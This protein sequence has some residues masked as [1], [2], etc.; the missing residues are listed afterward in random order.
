M[1]KCVIECPHCAYRANVSEELVGKK[2]KCPKCQQ[3][4][5]I[6][7]AKTPEEIVASITTADLLLQKEKQRLRTILEAQLEELRKYQY[8]S[9]RNIIHFQEHLSIERL[10]R[11]QE[12]LSIE[13]LKK[14][15][16]YLS[17]E[18]LKKLK[19]YLS[20]ERLRKLNCFGNADEGVIAELNAAIEKE[21]AILKKLDAVF[22]RVHGV[23][24]PVLSQGN[25]QEIPANLNEDYLNTLV[26]THKFSREETEQVHAESKELLSNLGDWNERRRAVFVKLAVKIAVI[27][28]AFVLVISCISSITSCCRGA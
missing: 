3:I 20:I 15:K 17:I 12:C 6:E 14:L 22:C 25:L 28:V 2:T 7:V 19:D 26:E 10:D 5:T 8:V 11:F 9:D 4:F 18:R 21:Q 1:A 16:D 23:M 27:V 13:N 24:Y